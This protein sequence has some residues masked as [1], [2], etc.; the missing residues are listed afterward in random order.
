MKFLGKPY[1]KNYFSNDN[2]FG[3]FCNFALKTLDKYA[4][5]KEKHIR[6]Y[7]MLVL[8]DK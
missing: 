7:Q 5:C 6:D 1:Q 2:V 8:H 4:P 3:K